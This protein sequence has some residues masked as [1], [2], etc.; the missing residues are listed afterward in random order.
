[1]VGIVVRPS[2]ICAR[3]CVFN[4]RHTIHLKPKKKKPAGPPAV[5][6]CALYTIESLASFLIK[7]WE[8]ADN[9]YTLSKKKYYP[10]IGEEKFCPSIQSSST[11]EKQ[12]MQ[13]WKDTQG[14]K[15]KH[16]ICSMRQEDKQYSRAMGAKGVTQTS[17]WGVK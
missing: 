3:G 17:S 10:L 4:V 7:Y 9:F 14:S 5:Y 16:M 8:P 11:A 6:N 1:M 12:H 2:Q 13:R 15:N